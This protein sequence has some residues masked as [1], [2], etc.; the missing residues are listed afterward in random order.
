MRLKTLLV[1]TTRALIL[2]LFLSGCAMLSQEKIEKKFMITRSWARYTPESEYMGAQ[3][4]NVMAP[5]LYKDMVIAGNEI[6]GINAYDRKSGRKI[7]SKRLSGGVTASGKVDS[8]ILFFGAGDGFFYALHAD[9]GRTKWV[10]PLKAEGLSAP[11]VTED[12]VYFL[13][14]NNSAYALK[15]NT[16]EQIWYYGRQDSANISVRGASEPSI[17][18]EQILVGFSDGY[19]VALDRLKGSMLWERQLGLTA[20]FRDVDAKAVVDGDR[21]YVSSYD[22]QLYCLK[23]SDGQTLWTHDDGG[24]T[25][26]TI[27]GDRIFF[28]SS[29]RKVLA[30]E[31]SSGRVI[32]SIDLKQQVTGQPTLTKGLVL[33]GEWGGR[34]LALD[35]MKGQLVTDFNT[36]RGVTS[37]VITASRSDD[38]Y[39][40]TADANL[41]ALKLKREDRSDL[42]PWE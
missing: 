25:P 20:R 23:V 36:G 8:G 31:K 34:L 11:L 21:L 9:N 10:F 6:D 38:I 28:S 17:A 22:G 27:S 16:G 3:I 42:W 29:T 18:G 19:L 4:N 39:V 15:K 7:W 37:R 2:S 41:F 5:I 26:V 40:M 35:E 30:L 33:V 12:A 1:T 24:F 14:G 32:W 13:A